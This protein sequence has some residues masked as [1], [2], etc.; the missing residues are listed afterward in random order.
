M[1]VTVSFV[2]EL[3]PILVGMNNPASA[4]PE[5]ALHPSPHGCSG[6][7]LWLM[8]HEVSGAS[9]RDYTEGFERRNLVA[10]EWGRRATRK[11][12]ARFTPPPAGANIVVLGAETARSLGLD[13]RLVDPQTREGWPGVAVRVVPHP[14]GRNPWFHDEMHRLVVGLLLEEM[15]YGTV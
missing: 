4:R 6:H 7:R 13:P 11:A 9:R 15:L 5:H 14:S 8:L 10:G 3:K 1:T 2:S 12:A